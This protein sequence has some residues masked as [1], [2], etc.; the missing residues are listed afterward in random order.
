MLK[1]DDETAKLLEVAYQGAD[2][3]RRRR[4]IFDDLAPAAGDRVLDLGCG[5]GL[6]TLELA[7]AVGASGGI[8]GLDP[9]PDMRALAQDRCKDFPQVSI[10]DGA[11]YALPCPDSGFDK[12]ASL[13]VFE[14]LDDL[15]RA[16]GECLR[17]LCPGGR[18]VV[19][20]VHWDTLA[21]FSDDPA[22]M[23]A[24]QR[25]WDRHLVDRIVPARLPAILRSAGFADVTL[26]PVPFVDTTLRPDGLANMVI[27]LMTGYAIQTEPDLVGTVRDWAAEQRQ[28]A[29][30]GRFFFSVTSFTISARKPDV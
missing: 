25:I 13:Q 11:A 4:A 21:W 8:V 5:N 1:F 28:L 3:T 15:P 27:A 29:Q 2:I 16:A 9:S 6:L 19:G 30:E 7:R 23:T 20:D 14:Y 26:R 17:V 10:R 12:L 24:M 18:L 22:R